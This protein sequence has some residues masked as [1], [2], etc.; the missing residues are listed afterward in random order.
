MHIP[1]TFGW[2]GASP[3]VLAMEPWDFTFKESTKQ[4]KYDISV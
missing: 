4:M 3:N 2:Y 1:Y